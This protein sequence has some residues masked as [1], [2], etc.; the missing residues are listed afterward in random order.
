MGYPTLQPSHSTIWTV[1]ERQHG[2]VTRRQLLELGLSAKAIKHRIANGRLYPV[3][4]G[5]YVVGRPQLTLY[6]RWMAA[7]LTCGPEAALSH[8]SA[9]ALWEILPR[10]HR[11]EVSVPHGARR[12]RPGIVIHRRSALG[13]CEVTRRRA[14]PV[15]NPISTLVDIAS[16]LERNQLEAAIN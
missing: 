11:L 13:A 14:I 7:V 2:V 15:T 6:G 3:W 5:V 9:A 10:W 1:A 12:S 4:R 8:E 16:R